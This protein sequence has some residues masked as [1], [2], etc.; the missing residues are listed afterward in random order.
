[1]EID[2]NTLIKLLE[3]FADTSE[4]L[5]REFM[6]YQML[7]SSA[8]KARGLNETQALKA[9]EQ[10]RELLAPKISDTC[11][12]DYLALL[13]KL[14]QIVDML[15]SRKDEAFRLLKEWTPKGPPN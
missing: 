3:A 9:V 15:D 5:Q 10:G 13:A 2:R 7:F 12:K 8:C 6:L 11:R 1:M 4:V 14:P